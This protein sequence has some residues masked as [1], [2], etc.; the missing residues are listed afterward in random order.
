MRPLKKKN[1][2][3]MWMAFCFVPA[4]AQTSNQQ[5]F[6][7]LSR[8]CVTMVP[9][10]PEGVL[11]M[12]ENLNFPYAQ[13]AFLQALTDRGTAVYLPEVNTN[14][15]KPQFRLK[16]E[17]LVVRYEQGANTGMVRRVLTVQLGMQVLAP[18]G[19]IHF[20]ETCVKRLEDQVARKNLEHIQDNRFPETVGTPPIPRSPVWIRTAV[21]SAAIGIT[22]YLLFTVRSASGEN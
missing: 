5:H 17:A 7:N 6:A 19:R 14:S 22:T 15:G 16:P 2:P 18:D 8:E 21:L 11:W 12:P 10:L 13:Q 20:T 3:L 9:T 1:M 4:F